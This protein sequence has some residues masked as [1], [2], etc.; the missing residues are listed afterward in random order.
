MSLKVYRASRWSAIDVDG[1]CVFEHHKW[2]A[3]NLAFPGIETDGHHGQLAT[4]KK[5]PYIATGIQGKHGFCSGFQDAAH[6]LLG[7]RLAR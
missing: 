2:F 5:I 3:G 6:R 7:S 4:E 1:A